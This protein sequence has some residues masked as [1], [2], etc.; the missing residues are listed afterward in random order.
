MFCVQPLSEFVE[1]FLADALRDNPTIGAEVMTNLDKQFRKAEREERDNDN[2]SVTVDGASVE[3]G[4]PTADETR[5]TGQFRFLCWYAAHLGRLN[6]R[7]ANF[8]L[9]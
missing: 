3:K 8:F 7:S 6:L 1:R 5:L 4:E 2:E 9:K